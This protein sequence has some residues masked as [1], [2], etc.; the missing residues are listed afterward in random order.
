MNIDELILKILEQ[1]ND[2][3]LEEIKVDLSRICVAGFG[4][5]KFDLGYIDYLYKHYN[6]DI[7][8]IYNIQ[9]ALANS[10]DN[11]QVSKVINIRNYLIKIAIIR[12]CSKKGIQCEI[13]KMDDINYCMGLLN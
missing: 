11:I 2:S 12:I 9:S 8:V 5:D 4:N 1:K 10:M 13:Q 7:Q 6:K 3:E